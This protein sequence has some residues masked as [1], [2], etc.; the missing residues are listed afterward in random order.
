[1]IILS[2]WENASSGRRKKII[3]HTCCHIYLR[4]ISEIPTASTCE[5]IFNAWMA[6]ANRKILNRGQKETPTTPTTWKKKLQQQH[7]GKCSTQMFQY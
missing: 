6:R 4:S 3:S 1:M 2:P 5:W 7:E